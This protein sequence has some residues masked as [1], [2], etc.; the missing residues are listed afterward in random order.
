MKPANF[1]PIA[2]PYRWLE[3]LTLGP[4]LQRCRTHFL[5]Q[6]LD[7]RHALVLGDGD[8]RFLAQLLATNHDLRA[9]AVDTSATMLHLLSQ[10]CARITTTRLRTHHHSA[11][12]HS[13][14]AATDLIAAHFFFDC[15]TQPELNTLIVRLSRHVRPDTLWLISD[16]RIPSGPLSRPARLYIRA[17]YAAFRLLTGL[18]VTHLPDHET[19]LQAAGLTRTHQHLSLFGLLSTEIWVRL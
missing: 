19:P 4:A 9:D 14:R 3:Y 11:L 12:E 15:L 13:P 7:R 10:R 6:L 2:R 18:R 17:L 1:D 16:F 8:G 5:P